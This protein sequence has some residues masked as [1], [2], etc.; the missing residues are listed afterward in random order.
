MDLLYMK[1]MLSKAEW[2]RYSIHLRSLNA[3]HFGMVKA[4]GLKL[5]HRGYLQW[6][7][8]PTKF[9]ENTQISSEIIREG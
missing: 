5:W 3:S 7:H 4:K 2:C 1:P 8:L 9:H 6:H